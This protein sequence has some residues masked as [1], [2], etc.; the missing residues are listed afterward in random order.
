MTGNCTL[1]LSN[2]VVG[3][4]YVLKLVQD[5]TGSRTMAWPAAVTWPAGTAPTL[6]GASKVD[7]IT[8]YWDGT[9]YFGTF[10]VNYTV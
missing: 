7:V 10:S 5:A 6:S 9:N 1:T 3:Q 8:L 4:V 2:P